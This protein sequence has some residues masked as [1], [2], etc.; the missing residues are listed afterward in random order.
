MGIFQ[1]IKA[2]VSKRADQAKNLVIRELKAN[3][4]PSRASL[5]LSLGV[6][7]GFSPLYGLQ[8]VLL[9]L[10]AFVLRLNRPLALL[11]GS[12][13][14]LPLVPFWVA[15]G[16]FTGKM[17]IP[18]SVVKRSLDTGKTM[19]PLAS[20]GHA[21]ATAFTGIR[22]LLPAE[23]LVKIDRQSGQELLAGF[24]QWAIGC[25]VFAVICAVTTVIITY[26]LFKRLRSAR[27]ARDHIQGEKQ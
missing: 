21:A 4:S 18:I 22:R 9:L 15:A 5:S 12:T 26:P 7:V 2:F 14:P 8:T 27:K 19:F 25:S 13:T 23:M 10:L 3:T 17:V 16:I 20:L 24:V 11:G 6:L 1:S